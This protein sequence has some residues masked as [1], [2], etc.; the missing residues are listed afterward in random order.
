MCHHRVPTL[1]RRS[2]S[3]CLFLRSPDHQ[4]RDIRSTVVLT[5]RAELLCMHPWWVPRLAFPDSRR[6]QTGVSVPCRDDLHTTGHPHPLPQSGRGR[7]VR[8]FWLLGIYLCL[9]LAS[10]AHVSTL[11]SSHTHKQTVVQVTGALS[12]ARTFRPAAADGA[13][14]KVTSHRPS[15]TDTRRG[16][17]WVGNLCVADRGLAR[18]QGWR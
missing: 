18:L 1:S 8:Y 13:C 17:R 2:Q 6:R 14:G 7:E 10:V 9:R 11:P 15:H 16:C 3:H 12:L 4:F 5:A